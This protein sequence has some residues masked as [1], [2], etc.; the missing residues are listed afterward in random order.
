MQH[1]ASIEISPAISN[2]TTTKQDVAT[3]ADYL[4]SRIVVRLPQSKQV[5][6]AYLMIFTEQAARKG[7]K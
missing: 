2:F 1:K 5:K 4:Q 6:I 7:C 3:E